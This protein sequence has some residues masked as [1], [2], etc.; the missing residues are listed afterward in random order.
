MEKERCEEAMKELKITEM[1]PCDI[2]P[3]TSND[4]ERMM[5]GFQIFKKTMFD[6]YPKWFSK[7]AEGQSPKFLVFACSDSRVSPS[8]VLQFQP[9]EAFM[10][11]NIANMVPPYD[12]VRYAGT[13]AVIEYAVLHLK[14][15]NIVVIGHSRC[16]GIEAL[17]KIPEDGSTTTDFIEDWVKIGLPARDKV[18]N[19]HGDLSFEEQCKY[20]EKEAVNVSLV[21]LLSYPFVKDAVASQKLTLYGGYYDF[22]CGGFELWSAQFGLTPPIKA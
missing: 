20:C 8:H 2:I 9:G 14:V 10:V 11:R 18:L 6:K 17:M 22:V 3:P 16:G 12:K 4:V 1:P 19:E 21:N 13:G 7:L 15:E 5:V